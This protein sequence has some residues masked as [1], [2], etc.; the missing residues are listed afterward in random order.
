MPAAAEEAAPFAAEVTA[1][2]LLA[3]VVEEGAANVEAVVLDVMGTAVL[4]ATAD[5]L[6]DAGGAAAAEDTDDL[7]AAA[8]LEP[9][10][11]FEVEAKGPFALPIRAGAAAP[12]DAVED[13]PV[14]ERAEETVG[15]DEATEEEVLVVVVAPIPR[16]DVL[17][18]LL[19]EA[20]E[21]DGAAI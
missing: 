6:T 12:A 5:V 19:A 3:E 11:P 4:L 21:V 14:R 15:R 1:A 8:E 20:E 2:T 16:R 10:L 7:L 13:V 9:M 18:R 17:A